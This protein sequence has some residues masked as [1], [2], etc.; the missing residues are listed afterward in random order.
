MRNVVAFVLLAGVSLL[1]QQGPDELPNGQPVLRR[2]T[3][4]DVS[5]AREEA[6]PKRHLIVPAGTRIPLQ[7]TQ[8]ISTS[9]AQPGD[10]IYGQT[11]FPIVVNE[12]VVIPPGTYVQGV[13]DAVKRAG[14]I[15][16]TAE[17]QFHL[18]TL[19]YRNGYTVNLAAAIEQVPGDDNSHVTEQGTIRHDSEEGRDIQRIGGGAAA[20]G[21]LGGM[22]G[23]A[24]SG[25][26][27]GFGIGALGGIA[28][29]SAI[30]TLA[31]GSDLQFRPGTVLNVS[32][33][34]AIAID[35]ERVAPNVSAPVFYPMRRDMQAPMPR[36]M[37]APMP[38][39]RATTS[40]RIPY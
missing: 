30:G 11:T 39:P 12:Q 32:L 6:Q 9:N 7:L 18:T 20:A 16:G 36:N 24:A 5:E 23:A 22:A 34:H 28:A 35:P 1:A 10:P 4:V 3:A 27:R 19:L 38:L 21:T 37:Q 40:S 29:G 26:T 17:L 14:R 2:R 31:R 25:T 8:G 13:V 33:T 15:K